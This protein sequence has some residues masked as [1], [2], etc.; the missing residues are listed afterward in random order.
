VH[1]LAARFGAGEVDLLDVRQPGEWAAGHV[2]GAT[3]L[4][5]AALPA[6]A[7]ELAEGRPLAVMCGSGFRSSV[8]ASLLLSRGRLG[9]LNVAGGMAA[10][11]TARYPIET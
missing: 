11:K 6:Q 5:G 10:W 7:G 2:G 3:F 9:V 4:T 8:A 1:E